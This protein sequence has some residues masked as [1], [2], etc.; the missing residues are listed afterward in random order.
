MQFP[1]R[2]LRNDFR[3]SNYSCSCNRDAKQIYQSCLLV[4]YQRFPSEYVMRP[5]RI[6]RIADLGYGSERDLNKTAVGVCNMAMLIGGT[7]CQQDNLVDAEG[8]LQRPVAAFRNWITA[9]GAPGST[10]SCG[11]KAEPGRYHLYVARACPWAHR[12]TIFR[13]I[14][15]LQS[16]IGLWVEFVPLG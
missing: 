9:D 8:R 14:K 7:W 5:A 11:F 16:M 15:G 3:S 2:A 6:D 12:T 13:E 1:L 10:G 4:V